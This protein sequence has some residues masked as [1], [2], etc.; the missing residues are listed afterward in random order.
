M[1]PHFVLCQT[2]AKKWSYE[3][4]FVSYL[5]SNFL[6]HFPVQRKYTYKGFQNNKQTS[7]HQSYKLNTKITDVST[8]NI[9]KNPTKQTLKKQPTRTN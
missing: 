4:F 9:K 6:T 3:C 7:V 1:C 8:H 5:N 2:D